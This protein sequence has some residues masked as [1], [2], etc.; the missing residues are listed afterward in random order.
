MAVPDETK[1]TKVSPFKNLINRRVPQIMGI[2]LAASWGI[3]QFVE[4][5]VNRYLLSPNL[6]DLAL[7]IVLSFIPSSL[8]VAY[9]HGRPG[10]DRW[11][12]TEK[13]GIPFN[14]AIT[15]FLVL[16][17]FGDKDLGPVS[18][19]VAVEDETGKKIERL[20]PKSNFR[21]KIAMFTF[22]NKTGD[23]SLDWV[24]Y[25]VSLMYAFDLSQDMFFEVVTPY[26][27][28]MAFLD[29]YIY[30]KI[31][32]A[33][34]PDMLGIPLSLQRKIAR[35]SYMEYFLT[36]KISREGEE[37]ILESSLYL[38]KNSK[39][40]AQT[41]V[42]GKD[43]FK[44]IDDL[45]VRLKED[46]ELP[47]G[48]IEETDDLPVSEMF[49]NSLEAARL[50]TLGQN[51]TAV[52][53][54]RAKAQD[55]YERAIREDPTF[56]L[57]YSHL[58]VIYIITN[59]NQKGVETIQASM[60]YSYK[61][62]ERWQLYTKISYFTNVKQ[63]PEKRMAVLK[64]MVKLYPEDLQAHAFLALYLTLGNMTDEAI[65]TYKRMLEIDPRRYEI[66][67]E[68]GSLYEVQGRFEQAM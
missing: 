56:A 49:T 20:I 26:V 36:G 55:Y 50:F 64:M 67:E 11:K 43:L 18:Q 14:I 15:I 52:Q 39:L 38:T 42:R 34:Y 40:A 63:D 23:A 30:D 46:L 8:I 2:Y 9:Y 19:K 33:G 10:R 32:E 12:K 35:E 59:Q 31:K 6:T 3:I 22:D 48:Y 51:A 24:Q 5:I 53:R 60:K 4:W 68:I 54:D 58:G 7:V 17:F 41:T 27:Q 65:A 1:E 13:V 45:T 66:F 29:F 21:K 47:A 61:L 16:F 25:G 44:L 57:A 62:P 37:L 28:G